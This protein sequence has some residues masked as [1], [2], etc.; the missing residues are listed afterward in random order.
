MLDSVIAV[1]DDR[2]QLILVNDGS[3]DICKWYSEKDSH[4]LYLEQKNLG[5]SAARN[6]GIKQA[7]G[8]YVYR[9]GDE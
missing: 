2:W 1:N 6:N 7:V 5:V 3:G 9:P 8:E 4:I